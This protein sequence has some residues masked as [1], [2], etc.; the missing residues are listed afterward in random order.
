MFL[1]GGGEKWLQSR[2]ITKNYVSEK[3]LEEVVQRMVK[4]S[5]GDKLGSGGPQDAGDG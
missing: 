1:G 3:M 4:T 2:N 5:L